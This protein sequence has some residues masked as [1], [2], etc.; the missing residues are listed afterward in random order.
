MAKPTPKCPHCGA[1]M[2]MYW[3]KITPGMTRALAKMRKAVSIKGENDIRIDK[4]PKSIA[5][6]HVERCNWQ[7]LRIHGLVARVKED[8]QVKRGRWLITNKGYDYLY[9]MAIHESVQSFRNKV[10]DHSPEMV[11]I[12]EVMHSDPY[13]QSI[14]DFKY[15]IKE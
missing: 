3:H 8:G 9:G 7:K 15:N 14:D 12:S 10:V 1:S 6:N 11:T 2:K 4:L 5:L 13:W